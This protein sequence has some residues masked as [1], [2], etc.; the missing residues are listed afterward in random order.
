[1]GWFS[2]TKPQKWLRRSLWKSASRR[3]IQ[4]F[5]DWGTLGRAGLFRF[6]T[7]AGIIVNRFETYAGHEYL[8][9][10]RVQNNFFIAGVRI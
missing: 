5:A 2:R 4:F 7:T 1:L 10:G 8:D 9:I 3:L 6:R